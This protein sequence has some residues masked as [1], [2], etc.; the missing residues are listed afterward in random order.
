MHVISVLVIDYN[1]WFLIARLVCLLLSVQRCL[2]TVNC[3][4]YSRLILYFIQK[5]NYFYIHYIAL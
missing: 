5:H 4:H 2:I 3:I 1:C